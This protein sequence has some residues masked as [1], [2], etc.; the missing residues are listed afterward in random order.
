MSILIKGMEMPK[1]CFYCPFRRKINPDDIQC[2]VTRD[3]FEETFAGTIEMR[4]RGF[5]PLVEI[6]PHGRLIDADVLEK[7]F[8]SHCDDYMSG[9]DECK[10]GC[11]DLK[12]IKSMPTVIPA[13]KDGET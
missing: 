11:F 2:L 5:C 3:V 8:C 12:I 13:D 6:P 1:S 10:E 4:N 9:K 7:K